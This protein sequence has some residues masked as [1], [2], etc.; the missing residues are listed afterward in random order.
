MMY[1]LGGPAIL[2]H[3]GDHL[4]DLGAGVEV[5]LLLGRV[6]V[7]CEYFI[8][9]VQSV[10]YCILAVDIILKGSQLYR[11]KHQSCEPGQS[12]KSD[13]KGRNHLQSIKK[14]RPSRERE[15][16]GEE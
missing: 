2:A 6:L 7:L 4:L 3:L 5:L 1:L 13:S 12:M 8:S 15:I 9:T 10:I 16:C 11:F 14:E